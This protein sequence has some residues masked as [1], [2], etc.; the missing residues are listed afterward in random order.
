M[1]AGDPN[2]V[3]VGIFKG[4]ADCAEDPN[5]D[6]D[7]DP[8]FDDNGDNCSQPIIV[9]YNMVRD[10]ADKHDKDG[11]AVDGTPNSAGNMK[12][13]YQKCIE[14]HPDQDPARKACMGIDA[15][16]RLR[17]EM[18]RL[19]ANYGANGTKPEKTADEAV[20]TWPYPPPCVTTAELK[21]YHDF[22]VKLWQAYYHSQFQ[23]ITLPDCHYQKVLTAKEFDDYVQGCYWRIDHGMWPYV[24]LLPSQQELESSYCKSQADQLY[25]LITA[26]WS[27]KYKGSFKRSQSDPG[28]LAF[29]VNKFQNDIYAAWLSIQHDKRGGVGIS[30]TDFVVVPGPPEQWL[31]FTHTDPPV[32]QDWCQT[33]GLGKLSYWGYGSTGAGDSALYFS[34]S[35][36]QAGVAAMRTFITSGAYKTKPPTYTPAKPLSGGSKKPA[37]G[38]G[39]PKATCSL[40]VSPI[41]NK[42]QPTTV[43]LT[44]TN[45]PPGVKYLAKGTNPDGSAPAPSENV[46]APFSNTFG[47]GAWYNG[48]Y[49]RWYEVYDASNKLVCASNKVSFVHS[50]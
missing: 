43:T 1:R 17:N 31:L 13:L 8:C 44:S 3:Y 41:D 38:G 42:G 30:T 15:S 40:T 45:V 9:H 32:Q 50:G 29:F 11:S 5:N 46:G 47:T 18:A 19:A 6:D 35:D 49:T 48:N 20:S 14:A 2:H 33:V 25:A 22:I 21:E 10:D 34:D 16:L 24:S 37:P 36:A 23:P 4:W 39:P 7:T 12:A 28:R 27:A 26:H